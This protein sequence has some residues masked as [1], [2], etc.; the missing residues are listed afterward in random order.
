MVYSPYKLIES[1]YIGFRIVYI[2]YYHVSYP[3]MSVMFVYDIYEIK[4]SLLI[5][6]G[7]Y[8]KSLRIRMFYIQQYEIA[9]LYHFICK[10][11]EICSAGVH[12]SVYSF[13]LESL[14]GLYEEFSLKERL[15]A[16]KSH[17]ALIS[18]IRHPPYGPV[19]YL[20]Y[21]YVSSSV[22]SPRIRI[23]AIQ[24]SCGTPLHKKY[25]S[26]PRTVHGSKS[27]YGM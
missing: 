12:R 20:V 26:D 5:P 4:Q 27:F 6:T 24:T 7:Y 11:I 18:V 13:L 19:Y 15:P 9:I 22:F 8:F 14:Y 3:Y 21:L 10:L 2:R 16:G 23:M 17:S 1:L 25:S